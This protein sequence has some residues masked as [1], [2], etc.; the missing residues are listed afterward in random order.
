MLTM[1]TGNPMH[2]VYKYHKKTSCKASKMRGKI[3]ERVQMMKSEASKVND[4]NLNFI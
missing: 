1:I 4:D 3:G 2:A